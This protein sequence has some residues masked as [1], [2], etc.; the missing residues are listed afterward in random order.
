MINTGKIKV[1]RAIIV[2]TMSA[3]RWEDVS[4]ELADWLFKFIQTGADSAPN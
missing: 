2:P 3:K 1:I 4:Q